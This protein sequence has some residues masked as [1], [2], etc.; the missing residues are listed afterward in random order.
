[1]KYLGLFLLLSIS[2]V[3][4]CEVKPSLFGESIYAGDDPEVVYGKLETSWNANSEIY[5][6]LYLRSTSVPKDAKLVIY[7][8]QKLLASKIVKINKSN[9]SDTY[10]I[11]N[12]DF[13]KDL[14]GR[15][16]DFPFTA[17]L[18]YQ[19]NGKKHCSQSIHFMV[20]K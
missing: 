3:F 6:T 1:M 5:D 13:K 18:E 15:N 8:D 9:K 4:S 17:K 11:S 2:N 12:L 20:T 14:I 16:Q 10:K 19:V 7:K